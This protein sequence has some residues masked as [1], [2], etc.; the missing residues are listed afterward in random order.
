MIQDF[1]Q[2][3]VSQHGVKFFEEEFRR[4][5]NLAQ[6]SDQYSPTVFFGVYHQEDLLKILNHKGP[7]I[8]IWGGNDMH[9]PQLSKISNHQ[10]S[11]PQTYT[12]AY[13]GEFSDLL[14]L[15]NITHKK[16]YVAI[17]DYSNFKPFPLGENIYVYKGVH[18]D[19]PNHYKWDEIVKPLIEVFGEDRITFTNH[20]PIDE[21][22][23]KVYKNC[24]TYIKPNPKGGCTT[25]WELGHMGIKT[26]GKSH[27]NIDIFTEYND[28]HHLID[29]IVEESKYIGKIRKD[30]SS[31]TKSIF[32]GPEWLTLK[33]WNE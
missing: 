26:L 33:F 25:M 4:I 27:P 11:T 18:G 10:K 17:K 29:L 28:I 1:K 13:P 7:K 16:L 23:D 8:I 5:W 30:I 9:P 32:T 3:W 19:R 24:F 6:Y 20:L 21:L 12:W 31:T 14:T 15:Y 22:V 2:A